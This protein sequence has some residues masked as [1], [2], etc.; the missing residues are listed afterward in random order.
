MHE[1]FA[2][3]RLVAF[4]FVKKTK[5]DLTFICTFT[6]IIHLIYLTFI[7]M[8]ISINVTEL[9]KTYILPLCRGEF[10]SHYLQNVFLFDGHCCMYLSSN[11]SRLLNICNCARDTIVQQSALA[12]E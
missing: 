12:L 2:G 3:V 9:T 4:E 11:K 10:L 1:I 8:F 6:F 5:T 7:Y